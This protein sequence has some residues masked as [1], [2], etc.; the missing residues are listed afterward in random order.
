[1]EDDKRS[2]MLKEVTMKAS[3]SPKVMMPSDIS[4]FSL[5]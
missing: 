2:K 4:A 1:M 3:D 5:M